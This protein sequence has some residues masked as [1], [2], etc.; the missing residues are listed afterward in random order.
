MRI[1]IIILIV[2][3][4][5]IH[6]QQDPGDPGPPYQLKVRDLTFRIDELSTRIDA[7]STR[8]DDV[9]GRVEDLVVKES[10]TELRVEL[11]ADV[12]FDF[13]RSELLP[14][15]EDTLT[16]AATFVRERNKGGIIR[17]EGYTD[18]KGSTSYNRK[19]S[20]ARAQSVRKWFEGH[21]LAGSRFFT[22]G[23]GA[24]KPVAPNTKPDGSDDPAGRQK[25]RRVEIAIRK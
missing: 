3:A 24:E 7:L 18:A 17:I 9:S 2:A 5:S 4:G 11:A 13:D 10:D 22:E 1:A 16:R 6:A 15:G 14:K 8:S 25:N 23:F 20:L 19:L 12:L 21:G